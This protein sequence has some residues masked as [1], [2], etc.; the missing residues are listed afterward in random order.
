MT[1]GPEGFPPRTHPMP[2]YPGPPPP[3][4]QQ[5]RWA[6]WLV[7]I[8]IP[9]TGIIVTLLVSGRGSSSDKEPSGAGGTGKGAAATAT[10]APEKGTPPKVRFSGEVRIELTHGGE[11]IDLDSAPPIV[12]Q[13]FKG[14]DINIGATSGDPTIG[15]EDS[16]L[17]LAPLP[18]GSGPVPG[19]AE[20]AER[21]EKNG[22]YHA[23][24]TRGARFCVQTQDGRTA[25]VRTVAAPT[26]GPVR[27]SVTVWEQPN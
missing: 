3:R 13:S 9:V 14:A 20:C 15:T 26:N 19:E 21:I 23:E 8:V 2:P 24:L 1:T 7:G 27:L 22:G 11:E 6:W 17:V 5:P 16:A 25:Y 12:G 18:P 4:P 10:A